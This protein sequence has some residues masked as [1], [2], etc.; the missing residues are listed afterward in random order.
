MLYDVLTSVRDK[1]GNHPI[2][3]A[4]TVVANIDFEAVT[5]DGNTQYHYISLPETF[6]NT[7]GYDG[8][9]SLW[10]EGI[11]YGLLFPQFHGR[12]HLNVRVFE[13]NLRKQEYT[14]MI[15]LKSHSYTSIEYDSPRY[16]SYTAALDFDDISEIED[17][18]EILKD[19]LDLFA[20][21]FGFRSRS[22]NPPG[23]RESSQLHTT[24]KANGVDYIETPMIK[25]E[26]LGGGKY[27][28]TFNFSG[29]RNRDGQYFL[30]R[31]CLFEP[32]STLHQDWVGACMRQ[33]ST[34]FALRKPAVISSHRV[35]YC[36]HID[37]ANRSMGIGAL[38]SLIKQIIR[39]W[40]EVEF[41]SV[42]QLGDLISGR[43]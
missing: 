20:K 24:L 26:H 30:V 3:T 22:F 11:E 38:Q 32:T 13:S 8:V 31:N 7:E 43:Q 19:G 23:G 41:M 34:A 10:K 2:W 36:G 37:E 1:N 29:K 33:I 6:V 12:E 39:Q 21:T 16:V 40:P 25:R 35:N 17:Q 27:R 15:N 28:K 5:R 42:P 14:T 4:L 9:W 18:K